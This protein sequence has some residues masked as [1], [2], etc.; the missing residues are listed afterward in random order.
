[1][2]HFPC[3]WFTMWNTMW[4]SITENNCQALPRICFFFKTGR[5]YKRYSKIIESKERRD[6]GGYVYKQKGSRFK[7][8]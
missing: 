7:Q 3:R 1:M 6:F 4:L 2:F 5:I 8:Q